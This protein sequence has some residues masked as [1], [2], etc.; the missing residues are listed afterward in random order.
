M[1]LV[2]QV[3]MALAG[4][5][6][7]VAPVIAPAQEAD[8]PARV[9]SINLC[10]DQLAML[11]AAPGQLVSVSPLAA[12]PNS[13]SMAEEAAAYPA[14]RGLAE[15]IFLLDPDLVLASSFTTPATRSMLTRLGVNVAVI[16]PAY[17][18]SDV[19]DRITRMGELLHRQ[20]TAADL[21]AQFDADLARL[22][23]RAPD[24][25]P[26]AG[27]YSANGYTS[28]SHSL[29]GEILATAGFRNIAEEA[30]LPIGGHLPLELLAMTDPDALIIG[31]RYPGA[32]RSEEIL[33]HPVVR[34]LASN[35]MQGSVTN[36][37]WVCGT[38]HVL[39]AIEEL[40]TLHDIGG[41]G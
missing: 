1:A 21:L 37:D 39:H 17:S 29:A 41:D 30:G 40:L 24:A 23:A 27:L 28:G 11:L 3:T 2:R 7:A 6:F 5:A 14:N 15:E 13:S 38:P 32:S 16:D 34:A 22:A 25:R 33:D 18:L 12:D 19:R 35:R 31:N 36:R 26:L 10:T 4:A 8:Q 20:E 9:V